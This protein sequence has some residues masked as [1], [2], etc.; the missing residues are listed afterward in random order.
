MA[1][2]WKRIGTGITERKAEVYTGE[3]AIPALHKS[4]A[5]W[6]ADCK[7]YGGQFGATSQHVIEICRIV[8]ATSDP[9]Y[10]PDSDADFA[11]RIIRSHKIAQAAIARGDADGAARAAYD[12]GVLAAQAKMKRDWE[13]HALRGKKNLDAIQNGSQESNR[14][15]HQD[16]GK[17]WKRWNVEAA[18]IWKRSPDLS[19]WR[20]AARV[21]DRLSLPDKIDTI[22]GRLKIPGKAR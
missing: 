21:K 16:R 5:Q 7:A 19:K 4:L 3:D 14:Q 9:P 18:Q 1:K 8:V 13:A 10:K 15:R 6:E 20:I 2:D 11:Q 17:E 12:V 22:A